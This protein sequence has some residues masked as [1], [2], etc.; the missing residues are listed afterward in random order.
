MS[1]PL[2][3][4]AERVSRFEGFVHPKL[5]LAGDAINAPDDL[6]EQALKEEPVELAPG[7]NADIDA[8]KKIQK[9]RND[10]TAGLQHAAGRVAIAGMKKDKDL[11]QAS[12]SFKIGLD[13]GETIVKRNHTHLAA[14]GSSETVTTQGHTRTSLSINGG[15]QLKLSRE[16]LKELAKKEL[17]GK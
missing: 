7:V 11:E 12:L 15:A 3:P 13:S 16:H 5:S 8:V 14:P 4:L 10:F 2:K 6:Y 9:H 1:E 17:G